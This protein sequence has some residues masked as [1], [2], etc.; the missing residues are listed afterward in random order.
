MKW[1]VVGLVTLLVAGTSG[2]VA[3][4]AMVGTD[5]IYSVSQ[6]DAVLRTHPA[7]LIGRVIRVRGVV[8]FCSVRA[9]CPPNTPPVLS[10]R[11]G[12]PSPDPSLELDYGPPSS[13]VAAL[14][15]VPFV[16]GY[17]PPPKHL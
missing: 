9:G 8:G 7:T 1:Q 11:L 15:D 5:P 13:L 4:R 2:F 17:I 6:V 16:G 14:R 10:P 12:P 3:A